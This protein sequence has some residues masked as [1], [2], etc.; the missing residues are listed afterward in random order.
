MSLQVLHNSTVA[1]FGTRMINNS[2]RNIVTAKGIAPLK[3][4]SSD[5][6]W[7]RHQRFEKA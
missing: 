4:S 1:I 7:E 2:M 6:F 3:I 5:S